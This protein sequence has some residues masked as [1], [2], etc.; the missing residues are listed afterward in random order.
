MVKEPRWIWFEIENE[1]CRNRRATANAG[2]GW[3]GDKQSIMEI[4]GVVVQ[5]MECMSPSISQRWKDHRDVYRSMDTLKQRLED[6]NC[7]R[8]DIKSTLDK[9]SEE[10]EIELRSE[11]ETWLRR[12]EMINEEV[13]DIE[14]RVRKA[15]FFS[16]AGLAKNVT[17]KMVEVDELREKGTF[18]EGLA[19]SITKRGDLLPTTTTLGG[20]TTFQRKVEEIWASLFDDKVAKIGVCGIGGIGKTTALEQINNR[21]LKEQKDKFDSVIWVTVSKDSSVWNLQDTIARKLGLDISNDNDQKTRAAKLY[22]RLGTRKRYVLILDDLWERYSLEDVGILEPTS[23]NGCKLIVTTRALDVCRGMDC[24]AIQMELLLEEEALSLFQSI[25]GC[26]V[27]SDPNLEVSLKEVVRECARLPLAV[28]TIAARLKGNARLDEWEIALEDLRECTKGSKYDGIFER[29]KY[30]YDRLNDKRLQDCLLYCALYS[31]DYPIDRNYVTEQLV[32]ERETRQSQIRRGRVILDRL[33]NVCLLHDTIDSKGN[34][35]VKMHDMVKHMA[36]QITCE[37]PRFLVKAGVGL[38]SIPEEEFW[39]VDLVR[40]SLNDNHI[41]DIPSS[42]EAPNC[43][44]L[45]TFLMSRNPFLGSI[46]DHFFLNMKKLSVLDLSNNKSL[47]NLPDSVSDLVTLTALFLRY[48]QRCRYVPSLAKLTNFRKLDLK[49][50]AINQVPQG[51]E[52]LLELR[53][54]DFGDTNIKIIPEGILFKLTNL[55]YLSLNGGWK[56]GPEVRGWELENMRKLETFEGVLYDINS[57]NTCVRSLE[58]SGAAS[59]KLQLGTGLRSPKKLMTYLGGLQ[60]M[61]NANYYS[62]KTLRSYL[63]SLKE[64]VLIE[65]PNLR[66]L[67]R[68]ERGA[69]MSPFPSGT[70]SSLIHLKICECDKIKKVF[71]VDSL[72]NLEELYLERCKQLKEIISTSSDDDDG[73]EGECDHRGVNILTLPKLRELRLSKLPQ[74]E[75]IPIVADSLQGILIEVCPKLK[76]LSILDREPCPPSLQRVSIRKVKWE[77]LKWDHLNAK[78]F[79][80]ALRTPA[81]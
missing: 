25:V 28:V 80:Q 47:Q 54:M 14:V 43:A 42:I 5:L 36:L 45:S 32:V 38:K 13:N 27:M 79:V 52:M 58:H 18:P 49:A 15:K 31:E 51:M 2:H 21:L 19:L 1:A 50:S 16:R 41:R 67:I 81:R 63:F 77:C 20:E 60:Q 46:P 26:N 74:L 68:W 39:K 61:E 35:C 30:S 44:N 48:C 29:L 23:Q 17:Q 69:S 64:L 72:P 53:Y 73:D 10:G 12:V 3:M 7:R 9:E 62:L 57:F 76:R 59:Y 22:A 66:G 75:S 78:D 6:L 34:K 65:L 11:V 37:S 33:V 55:Q 70:F 56:I 4:V 8:N 71:M 40:A 24:K